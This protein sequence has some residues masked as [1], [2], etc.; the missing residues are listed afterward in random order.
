MA[1]NAPLHIDRFDSLSLNFTFDVRQTVCA[2]MHLLDA[3]PCTMFNDDRDR[4][5]WQVL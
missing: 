5:P 2:R 3:K 1:I 4:L